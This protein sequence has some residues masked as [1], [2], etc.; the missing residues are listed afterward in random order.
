MSFQGLSV[1]RTTKLLK[2]PQ[3]KIRSRARKEKKYPWIATEIK[4]WKIK[5]CN[6][7]IETFF[8]VVN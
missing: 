3:P 7:I 6:R 5:G 8:V 4:G 1:Y 2:N